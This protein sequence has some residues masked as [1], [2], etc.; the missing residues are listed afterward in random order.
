[1]ASDGNGCVKDSSTESHP[2]GVDDILTEI[3][4]FGKFQ[5]LI[6]I[7]IFLVVIFNAVISVGFA[8][9]ASTVTYRFV[10]F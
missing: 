1:M 7:I 3:G 6:Y 4:E 9:T 5:R 8:F 2:F 10:T